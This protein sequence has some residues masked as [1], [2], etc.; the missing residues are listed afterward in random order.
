MKI[1]LFLVYFNLITFGYVGL[2][3]NKNI[4]H[5]NS[6]SFLKHY[7][8]NKSVYVLDNG[9]PVYYLINGGLWELGFMY[10][11]EFKRAG[12][13]GRYSKTNDSV[14]VFCKGFYGEE[15]SVWGRYKN[16]GHFKKL[17]TGKL[18]LINI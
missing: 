18:L 11:G 1:V 5:V 7:I 15:K 4:Y 10:N 6:N 8:S 3:E 2:F 14:F 17:D 16:T 13:T 12:V 9:T